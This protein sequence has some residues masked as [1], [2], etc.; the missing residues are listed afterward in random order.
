[1]G[2]LINNKKLEKDLRDWKGFLENKT[3]QKVTMPKAI[4]FAFE[5]RFW[6][7]FNNAKVRRKPRNKKEYVFRI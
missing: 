7:D 1:M 3:Q 2:I 5:N 4:R 6:E